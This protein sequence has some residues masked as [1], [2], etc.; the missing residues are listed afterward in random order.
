M[1]E[2]EIESW[3]DKNKD[4]HKKIGA[5]PLAVNRKILLMLCLKHGYNP[6]E[7]ASEFDGILAKLDNRNRE[8][9]EKAEAKRRED[10]KNWME[11][12]REELTKSVETACDG[13]WLSGPTAKCTRDS[14]GESC[15][16]EIDLHKPILRELLHKTMDVSRF[17][18]DA[19]RR[20]VGTYL[21]GLIDAGALCSK[22]NR[23]T[24]LKFRW[25]MPK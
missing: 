4:W 15:S 18:K 7:L 5:G 23:V 20:D 17:D 24:L 1:N 6:F 16:G 19:F 21:D 3:V 12:A 11:H 25:T 13:Q 10:A 14:K 22:C 2:K 9:R 8:D